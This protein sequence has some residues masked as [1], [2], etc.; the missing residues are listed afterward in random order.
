MHN[1]QMKVYLI[2]EDGDA[3]CWMAVTAQEAIQA[4]VKQFC[5]EVEAEGG[6]KLE[7]LPH[8]YWHRV[9]F[10]SCQLIGELKN[11]PCLT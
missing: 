2:Q 6:W 4:A 1:E 11:A 3:N 9:C 10:E 5:V 7:E 8:D